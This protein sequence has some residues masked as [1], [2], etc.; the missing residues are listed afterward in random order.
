MALIDV[1]WERCFATEQRGSRRWFQEPSAILTVQKFPDGSAPGFIHFALSLAFVGVEATSG[2]LVRGFRSTA[3]W[4]AIGESWFIRLQFKLFGADD[5]NFDR[6][7]H[8]RL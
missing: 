1:G 7:R 4:T 8:A 5:T 3:L 6:K 2:G